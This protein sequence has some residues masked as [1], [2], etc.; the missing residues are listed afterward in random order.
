M[1]LHVDIFLNY[2]LDILLLKNR[3]NY[4]IKTY[5]IKAVLFKKIRI[6]LIIK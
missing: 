6:F 3:E 2:I 4:Y 1:V 5:L